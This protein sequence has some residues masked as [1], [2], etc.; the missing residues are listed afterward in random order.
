VLSRSWCSASGSRGVAGDQ[1]L[2]LVD[3]RELE[4][5]SGAPDAVGDEFGLDGVDEALREG[6]VVGVADRSDRGPGRINSPW[7]LSRAATVFAPTNSPVLA[8]TAA[9]VWL[10]LCGSTPI[11][12]ILEVPS[13]GLTAN[14]ADRRR[15][16]LRRLARSYQVTPKVLGRRR[17][18]QP[19][20]VSPSE[21]HD[22]YGWPAASPRTNRPGRTTPARATRLTLSD[23]YRL[24]DRDLARTPPVET[25]PSR[26]R[27]R[28]SCYASAYDLGCAAPARPSQVAYF[29]AGATGLGFRP[30][31]TRGTAQGRARTPS[32]SGAGTRRAGS[33]RCSPTSATY[34]SRSERRP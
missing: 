5:G 7:P 27:A 28:R 20:A 11:T 13:F 14:G 17:A 34:G 25:D 33:R 18:T 31:L 24:K 4:L 15:T 22:S 9:A 2:R 8:R 16:N 26:G 1:A 23:S 21:R 6:I 12:I 19:L 10:R 32:G 29:S 30:I 3:A